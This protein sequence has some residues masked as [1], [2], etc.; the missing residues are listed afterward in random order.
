MKNKINIMLIE[1]HPEYRESIELVLSTTEDLLLARQFG[2]ADQ[3]LHVL[4]QKP[5]V[6]VPDIILLD[7]NLPG[8]SGIDA[9]PLL[10]KHSP[11]TPIIVLTQ[12]DHEADV[13]AAISA[14]ASGYLLKASTGSELIGGI[15][16][17]LNGGAPIDPK[18]ARYMVD[19]LSDKPQ[20][21]EKDCTL[22]ERELSVLTLQGE[23]LVKK[24]I[25]ERLDISTHTVDNYMRR[26]YEKLQVPNAPAAIA[27]AF[28]SGLFPR[29]S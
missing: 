9:L 13:L 7:L 23:G 12:S 28:R 24:E 5:P 25:A 3:A 17:V 29:N 15:R 6:E 10:K 19:F 1:D 26:I 22:S 16:T 20:H 2:T 14:G 11:Q 21:T 18:M 8:L 4:E 27:K